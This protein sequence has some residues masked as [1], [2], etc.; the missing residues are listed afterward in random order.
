VKVGPTCWTTGRGTRRWSRFV[1]WVAT[2]VRI[3]ENVWLAAVSTVTWIV[4]PC[5]N[6]DGFDTDW[7]VGRVTG[8]P[9]ESS[10]YGGVRISKSG[11]FCK[12]KK[13]GHKQH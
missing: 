4:P 8:A 6:V 1:E 5:E 2:P 9:L 11:W 12:R 7:M 10:K 3:S 13:N